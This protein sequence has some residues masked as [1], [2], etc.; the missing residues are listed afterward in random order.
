MYNIN[1]RMNWHIDVVYI[2]IT[3]IL[4][5]VHLLLPYYNARIK[6]IKK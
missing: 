4:Y 2:K 1:V 5:F 6:R 3:G